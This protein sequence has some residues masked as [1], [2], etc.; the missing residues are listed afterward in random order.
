[1]QRHELMQFGKGSKQVLPSGEGQQQGQKGQG[2]GWQSILLL[3]IHSPATPQHGRDALKGWLSNLFFK[4]TLYRAF[5][6]VPGAQGYSLLKRRENVI[7]SQLS[8]LYT[9]FCQEQD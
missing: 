7:S 6:L 4:R 2:Q 5:Y 1:M 9:N 3:P 8:D